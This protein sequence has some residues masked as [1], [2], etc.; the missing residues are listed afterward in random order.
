MS[1]QTATST[2]HKRTT[3]DD[4]HPSRIRPSAPLRT[5]ENFSREPSSLGRL[6]LATLLALFMPT[7]AGLGLRRLMISSG[8]DGSL[9]G[10]IAYTVT[11]LATVSAVVLLA[12]THEISP[13][14]FGLTLPTA[15]DLLW[16]VA[17][18]LTWVF[19]AYPVTEMGINR[20]LGIAP[21]PTISLSLQVSP[22]RALL[23]ISYA[24]MFGPLCEEI[25]FRGFAI[26]R[27]IS[28]GIPALAAGAL[29]L[30][31]FAAIHLVA[32][33]IGAAIFIL[34]WGSIPTALYLRQRNI[35][36]P[37]VMHFLNNSLAFF[38]LPLISN[39]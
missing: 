4:Q 3:N 13:L 22:P 15:D 8:I 30:L 24:L 36:A 2:T 39:R 34:F 26:P 9:A 7:A 12:Y 10:Q 20:L 6:P 32:F 19:V 31:A 16:G 28:F 1:C 38:V 27:L 21:M 29:S 37:L 5:A 17:G 18:F 33:G 25:L 14:A 35:A 23:E 11:S